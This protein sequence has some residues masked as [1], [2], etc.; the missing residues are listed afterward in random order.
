MKFKVTS[1]R[2]HHECD[3]A[4]E[5]GKTLFEKMTGRNRAA[6]PEELKAAVPESFHELDGLWREGN[7]GYAAM[8]LSPEKEISAVKE[9][10][11]AVEE[12]LFIAPVAGG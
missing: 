1:F 9:F 4:P 11:P 12:M 5:V 8:A 2:G 10:D 7:P 6:L 3:L